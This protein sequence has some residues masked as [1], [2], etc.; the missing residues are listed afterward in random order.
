MFGRIPNILPN[1]QYSLCA[2][3]TVLVAIFSNYELFI[4]FRTY[5][6][7]SKENIVIMKKFDFEILTV[8]RF[9]VFW[10]HLCYFYVDV[11]M[12]VCAYVCEWTRYRL[13]DAFDWAQICYI[14]HRLPKRSDFCECKIY[15]H[16]KK[17]KPM[18]SNY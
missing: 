9:E 13:N 17:I 7:L 8:I 18:E 5:I 6:L 15:I 16:K 11:C 12:Y 3:I 10:I 4:T 1:L 14:F 2:K